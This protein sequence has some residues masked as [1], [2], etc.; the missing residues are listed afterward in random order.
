M[1]RAARRRSKQADEPTPK[2]WAAHRMVLKE[3]F[4]EGWAPP[5]KLSRE[6]ME[7]I[8][9]LHRQDPEKFSTPFL[10]DKFKIS[11]EAVRR[12]LRSRWEPPKKKVDRILERERREWQEWLNVRRTEERNRQQE[13]LQMRN[14][15]P[16]EDKLTLT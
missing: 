13:L 12:I 2:E 4:P 1:G 7:G 15:A 5:R 10:A 16:D 14:G 6:G 3:M 8:R 11:P 9:A